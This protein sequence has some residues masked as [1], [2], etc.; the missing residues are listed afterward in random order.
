MSFNFTFLGVE[1]SNTTW[2][3]NFVLAFTCLWLDS[4]LLMERPSRK[5][6][7]KLVPTSILMQRVRNAKIILKWIVTANFIFLIYFYLNWMQKRFCFFRNGSKAPKGTREPWLWRLQS[8][9]RWHHWIWVRCEPNHSFV[10]H[11]IRSLRP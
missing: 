9:V 7:L 6:T 5:T 11:D 3:D 4:V 2:Q 10:K 8:K 1:T